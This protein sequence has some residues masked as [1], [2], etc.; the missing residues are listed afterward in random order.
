MPT[1]TLRN[2]KTHER[3]EIFCNWSELQ[4]TLKKDPDLVM[5]L[6]TPKIISGVGSVSGRHTDDGWKDTLKEIKKNSGEGNTIKV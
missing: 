5:V 1:Y 4:E 2:K 6:T 3:L